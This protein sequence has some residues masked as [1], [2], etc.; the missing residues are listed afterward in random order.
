MPERPLKIGKIELK[1]RIVVPPMVCFAW[2]GDDG[3]MT[4]KHLRHYEELGRGGAGLVIVEA[5]AISPRGRLHSTELGLW[6][7]AQIPGMRRVAE[8]IHAGGA[9]AFIQLVHAGGNGIDPEADAPSTMPYR[10][11]VCGVE[12][13]QE[14]ID[15]VQ[16][17]FVAASLRAKAAGFDGVEIHGCHSYLLSC[18]FSTKKNLRTD[19]YGRDR[20]LM[21]RQ[22]LEKVRAA[23]GE[24]YMV[25]IRLAAFEPTLEDGL[26]N[27]K[28]IAD[29]T[30]FLDISYGA[31]C[32]P[33]KP[34]GFPCS[35]AVYGA[36]RIKQA[37]P[38]V[39]VFGVDGI[40]S[41]EAVEAAL[42]TGIDAADVGRAHLV[43]P[44]FAV[45]V[46]RGEKAGTCLHCQN[47]CRWNAG[48]MADE[49]AVCPGRVR[50]E[51]AQ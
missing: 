37:L 22:V 13:T 33:E 9:R 15:R 43:D 14:A 48:R 23:C 40:G 39:P 26:R 3:M 51:R 4:E 44:A 45:H 46:L 31:E 47:Y 20:A 27:A 30:D 16:D 32:A 11:G 5:T 41:R 42:E 8:T 49:D 7:D 10:P 24:D 29:V 38:D 1:N 19:A 6:D 18:F 28:A 50:F 2:A 25:G 12:M 34:E 36:M 21:A 35:A 17:A